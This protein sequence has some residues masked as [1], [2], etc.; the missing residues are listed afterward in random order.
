V[1]WWLVYLA[2]LAALFV[3]VQTPG[4]APPAPLRPAPD[5]PLGLVQWHHRTFYLLLLGTP[6]EA[7]VLGGAPTWRWLGAVCFAAGV[8]TYR[9]AGTALGPSLSPLVSP[10]PGAPLVT[11]GPYRHVRHP[12]YLGQALIAL[13]APLTLGSRW[14]AWLAVPAVALL[15]IRSRRE[16]AALARAFPD[17]YPLH[18][19]QARRVVPFLF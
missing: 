15:A 2:L 7:L 8:A 14:V 10:R 3:R 19:R 16:D 5:E 1:I 6:V 17:E 9:I 13:G 4:A 12:M 11:T 18:A